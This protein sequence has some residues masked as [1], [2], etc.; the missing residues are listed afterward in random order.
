MPTLLADKDLNAPE[1]RPAAATGAARVGAE[2]REARLRLG[3]ALP[4]VAQGLRIRLPFLEAIEDGRLADLPGSAYAIGFL[5]TY[6]GTLGLD[7]DEVARRFRAEATEVNRKTELAFPAPVPERG[8]PAGAIVLVGAIIAAL[9]YGAWFRFSG[10]HTPGTHTVPPVPPRLASL[11]GPPASPSPQVASV[12]P[13]QAAT[14]QAAAPS[15]PIATAPSG[16]PSGPP[17]PPA[18]PA[19][20]VTAASPGAPAAASSA[21]PPPDVTPAASGAPAVPPAP[22]SAP[23]SAIVAAPEAA[24]AA[25]QVAIQATADSWVQVRDGQGHILLSRVLR[26][27]ETWPVPD[28]PNLTLTTGNA[29][30][31][32]L[33]VDGQAGPSL[34]KPGAVR[35]DVPLEPVAPAAAPGST[36]HPPAQ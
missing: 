18:A 5:R 17:A 21:P 10:D 27:G 20:A 9:S 34:G 14:P 4:D 19:P 26:A 2:L 23:E 3:W 30:G 33:L 12:M 35:R 15:A 31:T 11:A 22:E 7:A 28:Q 8:V 13:R 32:V 6:A 36:A 24:T 25:R 16:A 29:G 1:P